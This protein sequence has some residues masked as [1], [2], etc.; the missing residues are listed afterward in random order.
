MFH[1]TRETYNITAL[2]SLCVLNTFILYQ[3]RTPNMTTLT[4]VEQARRRSKMARTAL[5]AR[6][7]IKIK[8][9]KP[10]RPKII[11]MGPSDFILR[12]EGLYDTSLK[13]KLPF[14]W[15]KAFVQH[16]GI[17]SR[18]EYWAA[19]DHFKWEE[20]A[21]KVPNRVYA[22]EWQGWNDFLNTTNV[23]NARS[24]NPAFYRDYWSAVR[25]I[26]GLNLTSI[27][28]WKRFV[29]SDDLPLDIP[30]NP[31]AVYKEQWRGY[32]EWLGL[33]NNRVNV[34]DYEK[35]EFWILYTD[36]RMGVFW[37]TRLDIDKLATLHT[38]GVNIVRKYAY[39]RELGD[40]V[41]QLLQRHSVKYE[42]DERERAC[43]NIA[44]L[45]FDLDCI[46]LIS[47]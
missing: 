18:S 26:R 22:K 41:H 12:M 5:R 32:R 27:A 43:N 47:H 8:T 33:G 19:R 6:K 14:E 35:Q 4:P 40:Q 37:W 44:A 20:W 36:G 16:M 24:L 25:Y 17:Q 31:S 28:D 2:R 38:Y 23:F 34:A 42:D 10:G 9:G 7:R 29:D 3:P 45:T 21:P 13:G 11:D 15:L 30:E 46:L 39:E 1:G